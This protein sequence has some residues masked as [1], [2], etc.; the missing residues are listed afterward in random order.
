MSGQITDDGMTIDTRIKEYKGRGEV[1]LY[2]EL[3]FKR[4]PTLPEH[5]TKFMDE[6]QP[7]NE[8]QVLQFTAKI[9]AKK[10]VEWDAVDHEGKP[11]PLH[12]ESILKH[13]PFR[14][15]V[16]LRQIICTAE[17]AGDELLDSQ[18]KPQSDSDLLA[19]LSKNS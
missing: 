13:L 15:I 18:S 12:E 19:E 1:P 4:R 6:I 17:E 7:M 16:R 14:Q 11:V 9:I 2:R 8:T 3:N 5:V 10:V